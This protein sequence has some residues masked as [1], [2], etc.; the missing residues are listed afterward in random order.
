MGF[1]GYKGFVHA[2]GDVYVER[3]PVQPAN[4]AEVPNSPTS[5]AG[6]TARRVPANKGLTS[7]ANRALQPVP[8]ERRHPEP[9]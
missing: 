3:V 1:L 6:C 5:V 7:A 4:E 8:M 2:D 9:S